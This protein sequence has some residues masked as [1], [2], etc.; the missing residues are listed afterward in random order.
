MPRP[1]HLSP[2]LNNVLDPRQQEM[3]AELADEI[4]LNGQIHTTDIEA[5][6]NHNWWNMV[7]WVISPLTV[8]SAIF[9][10]ADIIFVL[11]IHGVKWALK[12]IDRADAITNWGMLLFDIFAL[13]ECCVF[14]MEDYETYKTSMSLLWMIKGKWQTPTI[15][16]DGIHRNNTD[17][18]PSEE[19]ISE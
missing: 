9:I 6:Y 7:L 12:Y 3:A 8:F 5:A 11:E 15:E 4:E 18:E 19:S 10:W 2:S 1:I 13:Y 16:N 17:Y 14:F